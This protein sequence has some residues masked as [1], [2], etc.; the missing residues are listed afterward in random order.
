MSLVQSFMGGCSFLEAS[1]V[2][3]VPRGVCCSLGS[4]W[5]SWWQ[6]GRHGCCQKR[7]AERAFVQRSDTTSMAVPP[8]L[9]VN[10]VLNEGKSLGLMIRGGSEYSLGIYITGVDKGSEAES[11]GL[12]VRVGW[13]GR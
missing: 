2:V 4:R 10:L 7:G 1:T 12:K 8:P 9:Q 5:E 11:T 6:R 13:G 3:A